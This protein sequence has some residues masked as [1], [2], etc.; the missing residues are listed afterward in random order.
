MWGWKWVCGYES[1]CVSWCMGLCMGVEVAVW[2][3]ECVGQVLYGSVWECRVGGV[4]VVSIVRGVVVE[5]VS[6]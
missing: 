5:G 1:M 6:V 2:V 4:S 3:C